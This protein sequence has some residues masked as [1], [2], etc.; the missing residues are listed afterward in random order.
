[1]EVVAEGGFMDKDGRVDCSFREFGTG[2][3][4]S[5]VADL[6]AGRVLYAYTVGLGT[7]DDRTRMELGDPHRVQILL[8]LLLGEL[9]VLE[10]LFKHF[11][12]LWPLNRASLT[13]KSSWSS[14]SSS[15][16]PSA[17]SSTISLLAEH[18]RLRAASLDMVP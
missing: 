14:S 10:I 4:I 2:A 1:M 16:I 15:S 6:D 9:L 13:M 8:K 18:L 7:V 17:A 11:V 5:A 12:P 3:G